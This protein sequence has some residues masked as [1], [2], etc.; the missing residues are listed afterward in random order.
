MLKFAGDTNFLVPQ[1]TD[2]SPEAEI[3]KSSLGLSKIKWK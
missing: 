3:L 1:I 2:V